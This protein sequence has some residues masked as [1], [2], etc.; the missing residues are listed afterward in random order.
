MK[1]LVKIK[2]YPNGLSIHLDP[3]S[4]FSELINELAAKFAESSAF[5]GT[6]K[7]PLCIEGREINDDEEFAIIEAIQN[8]SRLTITYLIEKAE[9]EIFENEIVVNTLSK[10]EEEQ[11]SLANAIK[12][13]D[14]TF[15]RKSVLPGETINSEGDL[16]IFGN[17]MKDAV[18]LS[19]RSI[20]IYGGLYG[21]AMAGTESGD[22][23]IIT[24]LEFDAQRLEIGDFVM[25]EK[26]KFTRWKK[27]NNFNAQMAFVKNG[28][29][30]ICEITKELL[31]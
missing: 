17:V 1:S 27:K 19:K 3:N 10:Q 30:N 12:E 16:V 26:K 5:F 8:N 23:Y 15:Y 18:V 13:D 29:I 2:S 21:Q 24:A 11:I 4:S 20:I 6:A 31:N 22:E 14:V 25:K 9:N 28:E 7:L